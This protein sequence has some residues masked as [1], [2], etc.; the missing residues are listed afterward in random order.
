MGGR[1]DGY[2]VAKGGED[3]GPQSAAVVASVAMG[4]QVAPGVLHDRFPDHRPLRLRHTAHEV[5][6][7]VRGEH[8]ARPQSTSRSHIDIRVLAE[9]AGDM[10]GQPDRE[11]DGQVGRVGYEI[12]FNR[13]FYEYV[14]PRKLEII[15]AELKQVEKEIADLLGEVTE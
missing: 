5:A 10:D 15:D 7:I 8:G 6:E 13:F 3:A 9:F 11:A 12:N 2:G 14:P 1:A 4:A